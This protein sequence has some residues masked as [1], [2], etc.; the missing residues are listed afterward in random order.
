MNK[1]AKFISGRVGAPTILLLGLIFA[2]LAF[3]PLAADK[4]DSAPGV[5]LPSNNETVLVDEALAELP[6]QDGTAA[7]IIYRAKDGGELSAADQEWLVGK[8]NPMS[9]VPMP[10]G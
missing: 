5:G 7:V 9:P 8:V 10:V 2:S 6:G 4:A 1:I 3:G